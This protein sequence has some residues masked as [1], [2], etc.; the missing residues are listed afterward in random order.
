MLKR[1]LLLIILCLW[2]S[3]IIAQ[4][5]VGAEYFIDTDPGVGNAIPIATGTPDD[6]VSII[7][8]I[9]TT[10]VT[11]G[12][13]RMYIRAFNDLGVWS[14]VEDKLFY[15]VDSTTSAPTFYNTNIAVEYFVDTDPGPGNG[16]AIPVT[17][18]DT[19]NVLASLPMTGYTPGFHYLYVRA[20]TTEGVWSVIDE[21]QFFIQD[22][23]SSNSTDY[24]TNTDVEYFIDTD[25]GLGSGTPITITPGDTVN[26]RS[27]IPT[28]GL[29]PGFHYLYLRAKTSEG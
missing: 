10:G 24:L 8:S 3:G 23:A 6:T 26:I 7:T 18:G 2:G 15:V 28:V 21:H 22:T 5:I 19:V 13:H 1:S 14:V 20:K 17:P 4:N 25:P 11:P 16:T 12:F 29:L 9:P 27:S